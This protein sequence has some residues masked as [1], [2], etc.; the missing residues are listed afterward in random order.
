VLQ[1]F[2]HSILFFFLAHFWNCHFELLFDGFNFFFFILFIVFFFRM[3][4]NKYFLRSFLSFFFFFNT[5]LLFFSN[6]TDLFRLDRWVIFSEGL[7]HREEGGRGLDWEDRLFLV[8]MITQHRPPLIS[9]AQAFI[10]S[11]R[12]DVF[13]G[14]SGNSGLVC[15]VCWGWLVYWLLF[16]SLFFIVCSTFLLK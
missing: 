4:K 5:S 14:A 15:H 2:L 3:E 13:S 16:F 6:I 7:S 8:C 10:I 12:R 1:D 9:S 11:L